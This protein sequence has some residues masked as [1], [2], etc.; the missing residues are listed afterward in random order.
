MVCYVSNSEEV[1][2]SEAHARDREPPG[3]GCCRLGAKCVCSCPGLARS[4]PDLL[5]T[6]PF[7]KARLDFARDILGI[8]DAEWSVDLAL[9]RKTELSLSNRKFDKACLATYK[10]YL[11]G[12]R[13]RP[14]ILYTDPLTLQTLNFLQILK[15]RGCLVLGVAYVCGKARADLRRRRHGC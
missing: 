4:T 5:E 12:K 3:A 13:W 6:R 9:Y 7:V 2:Y 14:R 10:V 8:L 1:C 11:P 15:S